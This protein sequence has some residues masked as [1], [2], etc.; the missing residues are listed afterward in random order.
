M[1][2]IVIML[3]IAALILFIIM[4]KRNKREEEEFYTSLQNF[5]ERELELMSMF[6][7]EVLDRARDIVIEE[8]ALKFLNREMSTSRVVRAKSRREVREAKEG[9]ERKSEVEDVKKERTV[10]YW[11]NVIVEEL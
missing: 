8:L 1:I 5:S 9:E 2:E 6:E 11:G 4:R 3:D 10:T 7:K